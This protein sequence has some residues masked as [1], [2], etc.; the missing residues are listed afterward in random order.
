MTI[1]KVLVAHN[2]YQQR[3]GEDAVVDAELE[4]LRQRGVQTRLYH[5]HNDDLNGKGRLAAVRDSFWSRQSWEE[6]DAILAEFQPDVVHVHNTFPLISPSIYWAAAGRNIPVVQTLHNFRL[7]CPQAMFLRDG[8]VCESC[9]GKFPLAGIRHGCYRQSRAQTAVIGMML[10]V[11]RAIGS[12]SQK[13][14]RYIALNEFSRRKFIE[15]GLPADKISIKPNFIDIAAPQAG[16]R[17]GF[18]FVGRLSE[19]KGIAVLARAYSATL[20]GALRVAGGGPEAGKLAGIAGLSALGLQTSAQVRELMVGSLALVLPSICYEQFP[21]TLVE[22]YASG[23]PV[24]VSRLGPMQELVD[25]GV[26]GLLFEPGNS[27]DLAE[28]MSWAK[29]NPEKMLAM[30]RNA[31]MKYERFYT[32]GR[33]YQQLMNIYEEAIQACK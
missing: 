29:D 31:R 27:V 22:A 5:R 14:T 23:L 18:L 20:H 7:L 30:G 9:L 8:S 3:G 4:M 28:K 17:E 33:N 6:A 26:T 11:N 25:E 24:I 32:P 19:E 16:L 21:M 10:G 15:G 12:Y 1:L 2:A 13:V